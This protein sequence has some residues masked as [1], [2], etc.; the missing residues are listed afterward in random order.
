MYEDDEQLTVHYVEFDE[1]TFKT[2]ARSSKFKSR[3][4]PRKHAA[5]YKNASWLRGVVMGLDDGLVTTLVTVVAL[6]Q[7][8]VTAHLLLVMVGVACASAISMALGGYASAKLSG[9]AHPI[10]QGIETGVSFLI[11]GFAPLLP[12]ALNLPYMQLFSYLCAAVVALLF[13]ALKARYTDEA[14]NAV[15]SALFFLAIV[16]IGTLAGVGIGAVLQ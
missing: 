6:T 1:N 4:V 11:G 8:A 2:P 5:R 15:Q 3:I 9:D 7:A 12:V 10:M 16:S 13:G 14:Q